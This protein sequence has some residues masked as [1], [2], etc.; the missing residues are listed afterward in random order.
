MLWHNARTKFPEH[1]IRIFY[2]NCAQSSLHAEHAGLKER[3]I[4][5]QKQL[6]NVEYFRYLG[7]HI[8]KY[9]RCACEIKPRIYIAKASEEDSF[10]QQ[11][12]LKFNERNIEV[13]H[14]E[15][16]FVRY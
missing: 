10:R 9:A 15:H 3:I 14:S 4:N 11:I 2:V 12:R 13:L 7:S 16:S 5:N 8:R 6:E 1:G